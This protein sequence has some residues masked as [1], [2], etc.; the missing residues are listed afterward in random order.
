M[1]AMQGQWHRHHAG[2]ALSRLAIKGRQAYAWL[3]QAGGRP[4][5]PHKQGAQKTAAIAPE[6]IPAGYTLAE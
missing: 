6:G 5:P 1:A 3:V 4:G 2:G